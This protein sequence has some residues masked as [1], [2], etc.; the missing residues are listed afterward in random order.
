MDYERTKIYDI[1]EPFR[2]LF[3]KSGNLIYVRNIYSDISE[4]RNEKYDRITSI[5]CFEHVEHLPEM[6]YITTKLLK[7]NGK[8]CITIPNE[9][10]FLWKFAYTITTGREFEKRYGLKYETIM[11]HEHIN[12]T[13]EIEQILKYYYKDV[14]CCLFGIGKTFSLFRYYECKFPKKE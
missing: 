8:L 4:I 6:V 11:R 13:D 3:E 10:K 9:G 2:E 7:K 5:G 1:V 14:K 12:T